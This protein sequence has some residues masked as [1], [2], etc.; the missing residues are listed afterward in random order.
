VPSPVR[1]KKS[2]SGKPTSQDVALVRLRSVSDT[3][4]L[5]LY[6]FLMS[7]VLASLQLLLKCRRIQIVRFSLSHPL[8]LRI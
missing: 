2:H 3:Y 1:E 6:E 4:F 8:L 5:D 7:R